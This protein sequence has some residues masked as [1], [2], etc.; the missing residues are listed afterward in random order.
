MSQAAKGGGTRAHVDII[1]C[2]PSHLPP[3]QLPR[4]TTGIESLLATLSLEAPSTEPAA[5]GGAA[6]RGKAAGAGASAKFGNKEKE[7]AVLIY[8]NKGKRATVVRG[9]D[10]FGVKLS[11]AS[12]VAALCTHTPSIPN[13]PFQAFKKKFASGG[14]VSLSADDVYEVGLTVFCIFVAPLFMQ[15][16]A[17]RDTGR[18]DQREGRACC[19]YSP[20]AKRLGDPKRAGALRALF[21]AL[22]RA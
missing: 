16:V 3:P 21:S 10:A 6:S 19:L 7:M 14:T 13:S 18:L 8:Q 22:H 17:G 11:D 9:L 2:I 1:A 20:Q 12:K 15:R 5:G 4:F